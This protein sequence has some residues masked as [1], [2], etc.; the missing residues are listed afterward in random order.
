MNQG[1]RGSPAAS[2]EPISV[3]IAPLAAHWLSAGYDHPGEVRIGEQGIYPRSI[4]VAV[5]EDDNGSAIDF[6]AARVHEAEES[7]R[8]RCFH[9]LVSF[10]NGTDGIALRLTLTLAIRRN[11]SSIQLWSGSG[12]RLTRHAGAPGAH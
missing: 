4:Q 2:R 3:A 9:G 7:L 1:V 8:V 11:G 10:R 12:A 6:T 5:E